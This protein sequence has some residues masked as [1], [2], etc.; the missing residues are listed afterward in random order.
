MLNGQVLTFYIP[1]LKKISGKKNN[2]K[3]CILKLH[4]FVDSINGN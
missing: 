1:N 2:D 4:L 3:I